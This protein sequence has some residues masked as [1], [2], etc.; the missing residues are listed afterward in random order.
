MIA[1]EELI[2]IPKPLASR[3]AFTVACTSPPCAPIPGTTSGILGAKARTRANSAGYVAPTTK[4]ICSSLFHSEC[5]SRAIRSNSRSLLGR[6]FGSADGVLK[7]ARGGEFGKSVRR[8]CQTDVRLASITGQFPR[9]HASADCSGWFVR[10][11]HQPGRP[12][13][14]MVRISRNETALSDESETRGAGLNAWP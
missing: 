11:S 2:I 4:Q 8:D 5:A 10:E 7:E 14:S 6:S 3:P 12:R 13:C 9:V 1:L